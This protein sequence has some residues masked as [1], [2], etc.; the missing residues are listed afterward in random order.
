MKKKM[1]GK[2]IAEYGLLIALAMVLSYVE[3]L[4]PFS[5]AVPG[6]KL[7]L[8]NIVVVF[9]LYRL[10]KTEAFVIS[11]LRVL[12]MT[13]MFGNAFA[14]FYSLSGA[15]LSFAVML[16]LLKINRFSHIG[17][18]I[19]GGVAHNIGQILCAMVL[20]GTKQIAYYLPVL[21]ISG[22]LAGIAIGVIAGIL[23]NR[24]KPGGAAKKSS[25]KQAN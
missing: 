20:L 4:I 19:G 12:L 25:G 24:V 21:L 18:G 5:V 16:L 22:T 11:M 15:I 1:T 17:V 6:V 9:A 23:I 7:G 10:G 13:F 14:L 8:A 2:Q 3:F